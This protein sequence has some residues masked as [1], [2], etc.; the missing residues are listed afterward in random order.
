[1]IGYLGPAGTFSQQ[2]ALQFCPGEEL[3]E[4][5]TI[6]AAIQAVEHGAAEAAIVPI[7]NSIEGSV[8]TTLDT[9]AVEAD[10][11]ITGEYVLKIRQ[12]LITKPGVGQAAI[13]KIVSHPQAIGQCARLLN[14]EFPDAVIAFADSTA[15]AAEEVLASDGE[16]AMIGSEQCASMNQLCI[17]IEDCGDD[18]TNATR[19]VRVEKKPKL[20]V[21][22]QDKSSIA[23][24]LPNTAGSL[25]Q[26]LSVFESY[27]INMIKIESRPVKKKFGEYIFFVDID[28]NIDD[29]NIYFALDKMRQNATFYKFLG[30]YQKA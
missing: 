10:L 25:Y 20:T 13:K 18:D 14:R 6:Y 3:K 16:V 30:S 12:N 7:E 17:L 21:T 27:G 5:A 23:F 22:E 2:A 4:F 15:K 28:G 24:M 9:L 11:F 8:N 26:A 29:A 19:F 1:M